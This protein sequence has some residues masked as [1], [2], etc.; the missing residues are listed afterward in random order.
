VQSDYIDGGSITNDLAVITPYVVTFQT[1]SPE[2]AQVLTGFASSP[3][4]F[5]VKSVSVQPA[6]AAGAPENMGAGMPGP[7]QPPPG[8]PDRRFMPNNQPGMPQPGAETGPA[9]KGGLQTVLKEQLL[10]II[11]E[12]DIVKLLPKS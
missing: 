7:G 11:I 1:F 6:N 3:N 9:G 10:H 12:V 8:Y 2:L 4:G 5:V